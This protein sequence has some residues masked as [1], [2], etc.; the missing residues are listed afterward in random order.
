MSPE[1]KFKNLSSLRGRESELSP[2]KM[3]VRRR[4]IKS[5]PKLPPAFR[6]KVKQN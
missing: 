6:M 1:D 3:S 5:S 4:D 2:S